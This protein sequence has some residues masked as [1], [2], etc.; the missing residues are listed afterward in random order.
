MKKMMA[1]SI[2]MLWV[3]SLTLPIAQAAENGDAGAGMSGTPQELADL[4][5]TL[6][7]DRLDTMEQNI[8]R[9]SETVNALS[10]RVQDLERTVDDYNGRQ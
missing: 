5:K 1:V 2:C 4:Q 8:A 3:L 10:D 9:L 6:R 7:S